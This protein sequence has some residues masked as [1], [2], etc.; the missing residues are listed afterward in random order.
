[1]PSHLVLLIASLW[2][3]D[4]RST[5]GR[6]LPYELAFSQIMTRLFTANSAQIIKI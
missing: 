3:N 6:S 5:L 2:H 1:M 4:I